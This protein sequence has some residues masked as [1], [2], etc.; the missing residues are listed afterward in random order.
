MSNSNRVIP[1]WNS[2]PFK[3][4]NSIVNHFLI[5][6]LFSLFLSCEKS[7]DGV[8]PQN[9]TR[10][11]VSNR[12][13]ENPNYN[14]TDGRLIIDDEENFN[15]IIGLLA[16]LQM[17]EEENLSS[18]K[19]LN[20]VLDEWED[21]NQFYSF[22]RT[23]IEEHGGSSDFNEDNL[24]IPDNIITT[25]LNPD[26]IFQVNPWIFKM[27]A[28]ERKVFVLNKENISLLP[29]LI[30]NEEFGDYEHI[31]EFTF[32]D[33]IWEILATEKAESEGLNRWPCFS[34]KAKNDDDSDGWNKYCEE[35]DDTEFKYTLKYE[36][37]GLIES[38][39]VKFK[40]RDNET[41]YDIEFDANLKPK[42]GDSYNKNQNFKWCFPNRPQIRYIAKSRKHRIYYHSVA[43]EAYFVLSSIKFTSRCFEGF[44][45]TFACPIGT[46]QSKSLC[47]SSK[48]S[49]CD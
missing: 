40:H 45:A 11:I 38:L 9:E 19:T 49:E 41:T 12:S 28:D 1:K 16:K 15:L 6:L 7:S 25:L 48:K 8:Y 13:L 18:T 14:V 20:N 47:V 37:F 43:L 17:N 44:N 5:L 32:D 35:D 23:Y 3:S 27:N 4:T 34:K 36:R 2:F 39:W 26:R 22:R 30:D 10:D 29:I 42:C 24:P 31:R 33:E 46:I 21:E